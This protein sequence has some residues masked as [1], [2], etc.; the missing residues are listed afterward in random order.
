LRERVRSDTRHRNEG[1]REPRQDLKLFPLRGEPEP[2]PLPLSPSALMLR[3]NVTEPRN[4]I[5]EK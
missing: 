5:V 2:A 3:S 4:D 1:D